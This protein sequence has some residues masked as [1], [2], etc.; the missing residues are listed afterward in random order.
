MK[1]LISITLAVLLL[2]AFA[3]SAFAASPITKDQY[4]ARSTLSGNEL[5]YYDALYS[6]MLQGHGVDGS[7]YGISKDRAYQIAQYV[8]GDAPELLDPYSFYSSTEEKEMKK[9][10]DQESANILSSQINS[11]MSDYEKVKTL[12]FYLGKS[13]VFDDSAADLI[14]KGKTNTKAIDNSQTAYGGIVS[15][16]A[17][18]AGIARSLQ[19]LLYQVGIPCYF[20]TGPLQGVD[21]AWNILQLDGK[22]YYCDLTIDMDV[23]KNGISP[24]NCFLYDN[25]FLDVG[26][27]ISKDTNPPIPDCT[28][29]KYMAGSTRTKY[30]LPGDLDNSS[31][32]P[33]ESPSASAANATPQP[34]NVSAVA[35]AVQ[36]SPSA[37]SQSTQINAAPPDY[38]IWF[39]VGGIAAAAVIIT[40][41]IRSKAKKKQGP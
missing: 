9:Q 1:K 36:P 39:L 33:S 38:S 40:L 22:W 8:Y 14:N 7:D 11:S 16:K 10:L 12:Y 34:S 27:H 31:P 41:I 15:Q 5:K 32:T 18:C 20:V 3:P 30:V 6:T 37:A 19:Y 4:Y 24:L 13:I 28:S 26:Y 35:A 2:F 17:V 25:S 21:H 29:T 23:I